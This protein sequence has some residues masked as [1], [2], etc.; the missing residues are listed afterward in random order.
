MRLPAHS[1]PR[2][3]LSLLEV[4]VSLSIFL[5]AVIGLGHLV[6][7]ASNLAYESRYRS[8]AALLCQAKMAEVQGGALKFDSQSDAPCEEDPDYH[9]SLNAEQGSVQGLYNVTVTVSRK[10][11]DG[12]SL[13]VSLSQM[14]LDPSVIGS[15]QDVPPAATTTEQQAGSSGSSGATGGAT[16]GAA[17]GG[18]TA[19]KGP[20]S[21]G[22]A[23]ATSA[24][25][26][27][28]TTPAKGPSS[29]GAAGATSAAKGGTTTPASKGA[30]GG[31]R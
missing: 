12:T 16:A 17:G 9:W 15:T 11:A 22:A 26:G 29:T 3:G 28:T 1:P 30:T 10:R 14:V 4:L 25:K 27:G 20:S 7:V 24:A 8:Q 6:I 31:K 19:A 5:M 21:T 2:P 18:A 23:G 13:E